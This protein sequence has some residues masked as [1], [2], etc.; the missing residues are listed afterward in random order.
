MVQVSVALSLHVNTQLEVAHRDTD[1]GYDPMD[2]NLRAPRI[3]KHARGKH[4]RRRAGG[5]QSSFRAAKGEILSVQ[6]ENPEL[7]DP[8]FG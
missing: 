7:S 5:I 3:D 2:V 6:S 1:D 4:R 8:D